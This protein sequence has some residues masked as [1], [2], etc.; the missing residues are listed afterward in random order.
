MPIRIPIW[1]CGVLVAVVLLPAWAGC[2]Q[3]PQE[4]S[5]E[6]MISATREVHDAGEVRNSVLPLFS[7]YR[8]S[9]AIPE[10]D[11]PPEITSLPL[12]ANRPTPVE[13]LWTGSSSNGLMFV[14]GGGFGH[15]GVVVTRSV[16]DQDILRL[17]GRKLSPWDS[18]GVGTGKRGNVKGSCE[19]VGPGKRGN[20]LTEGEMWP[21]LAR[22]GARAT[23]RV[24]RG[25]VPR[26]G[27]WQPGAEDL[28]R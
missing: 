23:H 26:D 22:N 24:S 27:P 4:N 25:G 5:V 16:D 2:K 21:K 3:K 10:T 18:E 13:V 11:I 12:F 6:R 20:G 1:C 7:R 15:C 19:G 14:T 17:H 8:T 9:E 28:R